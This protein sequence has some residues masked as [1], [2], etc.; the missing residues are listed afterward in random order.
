MKGAASL[1]KQGSSRL[2]HI[3]ESSNFKKPYRIWYTVNII[4]SPATPE[5][6]LQ[7]TAAIH[8]AATVEIPIKNPLSTMLE[9]DAIIE[10]DDLQGDGK[11]QLQPLASAIYQL[12]YSPTSVGEKSGRLVVIEIFIR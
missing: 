9:L 10:G 11:V 7:I 12:Q 5:K 6:Q 2:V 3:S 4:A 1:L 8:A